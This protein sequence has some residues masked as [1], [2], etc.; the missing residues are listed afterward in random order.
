M[1]LEK[2]TKTSRRL[3]FFSKIV[4]LLQSSALPRPDQEEPNPEGTSL[5]LLSKGRQQQSEISFLPLTRFGA[6]L[7]QVIIIDFP[8]YCGRIPGFDE[9]WIESSEAG[10]KSAALSLSSLRPSHRRTRHSTSICIHPLPRF[11][12]LGPEGDR[13]FEEEARREGE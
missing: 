12:L 11:L 1:I 6:S 7:G 5:R 9:V 4:F 8:L 13:A 10:R 3:R 2:G